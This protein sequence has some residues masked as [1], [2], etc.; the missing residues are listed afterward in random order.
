MNLLNH[1]VHSKILIQKL[2]SGSGYAGVEALA[3][4]GWRQVKLRGTATG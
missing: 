2:K 3:G 1:S 4:G